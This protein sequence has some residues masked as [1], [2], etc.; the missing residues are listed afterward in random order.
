MTGVQTCALPIFSRRWQVKASRWI[1]S[2]EHGLRV[3]G[4]RRRG[5]GPWLALDEAPI[6]LRDYL[7]AGHPEYQ[8]GSGNIMK[9]RRCLGPNL[10]SF[11]DL[12][13]YDIEVRVKGELTG[14]FSVAVDERKLITEEQTATHL[15][16]AARRAIQQQRS[17]A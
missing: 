16:K 14:T 10:R 11:D 12:R 3:V 15:R 8:Y 6:E 5:R 9:C 2:D 13:Q 1:G 7:M 17:R 4:V